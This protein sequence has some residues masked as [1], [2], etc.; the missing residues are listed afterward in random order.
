MNYSKEG[1]V[2]FESEEIEKLKHPFPW[3][4]ANSGGVMG[5][6][7]C[8]SQYHQRASYCNSHSDKFPK[9]KMYS[10]S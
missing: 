3:G 2:R 9:K 6:Y 7:F 4:T 10:Q 1:N 8:L 5:K